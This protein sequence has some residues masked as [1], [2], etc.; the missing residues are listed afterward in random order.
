MDHDERELLIASRY[1][2]FDLVKYLIDHGVKIETKDEVR[3]EFINI[4]F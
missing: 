4:E 1:G 2:Q 3:N